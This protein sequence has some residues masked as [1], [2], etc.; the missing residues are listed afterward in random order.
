MLTLTSTPYSIKDGKDDN[1]PLAHFWSSP[2]QVANGVEEMAKSPNGKIQF[3]AAHY[4]KLI[5][6]IKA[7]GM[8]DAA[9]DKHSHDFVAELMHDAIFMNGNPKQ[10]ADEF[11]KFVA[12]VDGAYQKMTGAAEG[13][14]ASILDLRGEEISLWKAL[15]DDRDIIRGESISPDSFSL[16]VVSDDARITVRNNRN[17][18]SAQLHRADENSLRRIKGQGI[19]RDKGGSTGDV[20]SRVSKD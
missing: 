14:A 19:V 9:M 17:A 11:A 7:I 3:L 18:S 5:A 6:A 10:Q 1:Q 12:Q 16:A 13:K 8:Q 4:S 15:A 20:Y 2:D